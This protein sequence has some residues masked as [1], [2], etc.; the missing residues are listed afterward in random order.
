MGHQK[1][2]RLVG[3][4]QPFHMQR[5]TLP[6]GALL[7]LDAMEPDLECATEKSPW[8][9]QSMTVGVCF[10]RASVSP[11]HQSLFWLGLCPAALPYRQGRPGHNTGRLP[12][13][14]RTGQDMGRTVQDTC[15][16]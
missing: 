5:K 2:S 11:I 8:A 12:G 15:P 14:S 4:H 16:G 10:G 7:L 13:Q 9:A 1:R 6:R 3:G